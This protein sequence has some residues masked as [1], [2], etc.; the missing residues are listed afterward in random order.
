MI[1]EPI[2][3]Y[4]GSISGKFGLPRQSGIAPSLKGRIVFEKGYGVADALR[5]L[6]GF[7]R[8]WLIWGFSENEGQW[9]PT[10]RPPRLG[11]NERVGVWASRS[12]FRPNSLGLSAVEIDKIEDG[13]V[14]VS[15]AD[16]M[17]GTPIYDIKPYVAYADAF[18]LSRSGF[19]QTA[20]APRLQVIFNVD[21]DAAAKAV[22]T[23]VLSL[24]P[25]PAYQGDR[26]GRI[27]GIVFDNQDVRFTVEGDILT[28]VEVKPK[29]ESL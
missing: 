15:G 25:R 26:K 17:D 18:P 29:P 6:E 27:Y 9:S 14:Y 12:P 7:E 4:R 28:V 23:E 13:V 24:D 22:L 20:P 5:G 10:V 3:Y 21:V 8:I 16:L 11:G 19:A 1:I 2:A